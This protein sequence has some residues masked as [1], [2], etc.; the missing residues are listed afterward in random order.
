MNVQDPSD[1]SINPRKLVHA[2][3]YW[4]SSISLNCSK[5]VS[6]IRETDESD[7]LQLNIAT[8]WPKCGLQYQTLLKSSAT[9][10]LKRKLKKHLL[11]E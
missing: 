5:E 9:F 10:T 7:F 3:D 11:H 8:T 4:K 2:G 1:H 6:G